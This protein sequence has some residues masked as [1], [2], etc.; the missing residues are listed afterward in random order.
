MDERL[1]KYISLI[2]LLFISLGLSSCSMFEGSRS[3]EKSI[4]ENMELDGDHMAVDS[5]EF[6]SSMA[7]ET[8]K[9]TVNKNLQE[10]INYWVDFFTGD[11][12]DRF[13]Q[14]LNN[15]EP[16]RQMIEAILEEHQ[17]PRELYYLPVIESGFVLHARSH[18]GAVGPWQFMTATGNSYGLSTN[19][20]LDERRNIVKSSQ[21]AAAHLRDLYNIFGSWELALAAYNAGPQR[22]MGIIIQGSHRE[23]WKL[24]EMGILPKETMDYIPKF[25]AAVMI[26]ENPSLYGMNVQRSEKPFDER[27]TQITLP[28]GLNLDDIS[29]ILKVDR[30]VLAE[31]NKDLLRGMI[32]HYENDYELLVPISALEL[33]ADEA[34]QTALNNR[35]QQSQQ[36]AV[37]RSS[38]GGDVQTYTV[39]R[40]DTLSTIASRFGVSVQS[41]ASANGIRNRSRIH[42]GQQLKI[43]NN[44][45]G[46]YTVRRGDTLGRIA[47]SFGLS[48]RQ[49]QQINGLRGTRIYPGQRLRVSAQQGPVYVVKSGDTLWDIA[50]SNGMSINQLVEMNS[51]DST[52]IYAGQ[53][54]VISQ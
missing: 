41:L 14:F 20:Y 44:F 33:Y 7:Q 39:R 37:A 2:T 34:V 48:V 23:Y 4:F 42:V 53:R 25:I 45:S 13:E 22:I 19:Y 15:G 49:I 6:Y 21:A 54:L 24:S 12:S 43:V 9:M 17:I 29:E 40:G 3:G 30:S 52:R 28:G 31:L 1:K 51:L 47:S 46:I 11:F 26:G 27:Y 50:R 36:R 18:M 16:Y 8:R 35:S 10:R 32:P 5:I 38:Q